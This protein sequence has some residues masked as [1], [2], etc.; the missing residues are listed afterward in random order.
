MRRTSSRARPLASGGSPASSSGGNSK[1]SEA[2]LCSSLR[3]SA[4]RFRAFNTSSSFVGVDKGADL[5]AS[6]RQVSPQQLD[7]PGHALL[8]QRAV[9]YVFVGERLLVHPRP[10]VTRVGPVHAQIRI[11]GGENAGELLEGGLA[12]AVASP[13]LVGLDGGVARH[14]NDPRPLLQLSPEGLDQG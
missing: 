11:L 6:A 14:V 13:A 3:C 2:S 10:H 9:A 5:V 8:R 4:K 7:Q 12:R 1:S